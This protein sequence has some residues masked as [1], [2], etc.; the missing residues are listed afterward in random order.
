[1]KNIG[2]TLMEIVNKTI[3]NGIKKNSNSV[4][5]N[6]TDAELTESEVPALKYGLKYGL[7]TR[8]SNSQM[9]AVV[10][11]IWDQ[12][13]RNDVLKEDHILK[14]RLPTDLKAFTYK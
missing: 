1:M 6:L 3:R 14:H 5:T 4:I 13:L 10:E 9:V 12:S 8:P 7:L 11:N 2:R